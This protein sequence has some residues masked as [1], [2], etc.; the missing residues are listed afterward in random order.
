MTR[1]FDVIVLGLGAMGSAAAW[2]LAKRGARVLGIDRFAPPHAN[3][4]SHGDTRITRLACGEGPAYTQFARRSHAIWREIE[5]ETGRNLL[6]QTGLL[7]I[8]GEGLRAAG[9]E[10]PV[11]L[12]TTIDAAEQHGIAHEILSA[13]EIRQRFPAFNVLDG[14]SG[15]F[16]PEAG[17]LRPEACVD[18]QLGL[19]QKRGAEIL[20]G[21]AVAG[22]EASDADVTVVTDRATHTADRL[23]VAAGMWLPGLLGWKY[24]ALFKVRRQVLYWF[25]V[26]EPSD[27]GEFRPDRLPVYIWQLPARQSIYG[28]PAID[29]SGVKIA[30]EQYDTVTTPDAVDRAVSA[31][32]TEEMVRTYVQP[33]FPKLGREA[34]KSA[35]CTYTCVED[36]RFIIDTHPDMRRV[37]VA[38]PCSG[39]GFKHSAA[40]G[41]A[42]A[43]LCV[44]GHARYDLSGF[45]F[46][47][48]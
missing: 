36:A 4:S 34:L 33:Y 19:A 30:T 12:Q 25:P 38:S 29:A 13:R 46:A 26:A 9:H 47:A 8:S 31:A 3:G 43:E 23:I 16:E 40:I 11:F 22:F 28:F 14:D 18:A 44:D 42:L 5:R 1:S 21:E 15:Y 41:E 48:S 7:V 39:H 45:G 6:T 24:A 37:I 2:Q 20:T 27:A 35:V 32:A 10:N 17:F